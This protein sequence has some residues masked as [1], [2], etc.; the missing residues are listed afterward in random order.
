MIVKIVERRDNRFDGQP[1]TGSWTAPTSQNIGMMRTENRAKPGLS[2][3]Y[4]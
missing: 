3:Y 2:Y 1:V 4:S